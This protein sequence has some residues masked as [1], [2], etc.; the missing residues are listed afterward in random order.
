MAAAA[1]K[2]AAAAAQQ[3]RSNRMPAGAAAALGRYP[4]LQQ[5]SAAV[6][7]VQDDLR[8]GRWREGWS[9]CGLML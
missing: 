5:L 9:T 6:I 1:A 3:Q 7:A 8:A 2:A 4:P